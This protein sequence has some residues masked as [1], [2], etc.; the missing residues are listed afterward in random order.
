MSNKKKNFRLLVRTSDVAP[1]RIPQTPHSHPVFTYFENTRGLY[2]YLF[3]VLLIQFFVFN[4]Y[5]LLKKLYLFLDIGSDSY[6]L[7]YPSFVESARHIRTDGIPTWSFNSGMG[8]SIFPGGLSSPFM[9]P[10]YLLGPDKLAYG[11]IF[12]ELS[13]MM[14]AGCIF[15]LYLTLLKFSKYT[16]VIG[17]ILASCMGYMVL[18]SSGWYGHSTNVVYFFLLIYAF[19]LFYIKNNPVVFPIAVFFIASDAFKILIYSVFLFTYILFRLI[20]DNKLK[21]NESIVFLVKLAGLGA[22]GLGMSA[23][24][25]LES[26]LEKINS[27]RVTGKVKLT[28]S[29][30]STPVFGL[31]DRLEAATEILRSFSNDL[32][33]VGSKYTGFKNYL[34]APTFYSGLLPLLLAPQVFL[35]E[36]SRKKIVSGVFLVVWMVP[37]IFPFFRYGLYAFMGNYYKN[38]LSMFIPAII[39]IFGLNGLEAICRQRRHSLYVLLGTLGLLLTI[40]YI[41]YFAGPPYADKHF[42]D[43]DL[44]T[45]VSCFLI[46]Y[47]GILCFMRFEAARVYAKTLLMLIVCAEM[48][49]FSYITVNQRNA[50]TKGQMESRIG[51]N[52]YTVDAVDYIKS[53]DSGFYR[54]SKDY[55]SS[56]AEASS[57]NDAKIQDYF[58]TPSYS[59]FN[60][61]EYI[62]FLNATEIIPKGQESK[63]RWAIG[64]IQRPFLQAVASV[65]YNL[66]KNE[67]YAQR[68]I[69]FKMVYENVVSFGDVTVLKNNFFLPLGFTYDQIIL[70]KDYESLSKPHKDMAM[71]CAALMDKEFPPLKTITASDMALTLKNFKLSDFSQMVGQ[72][73]AQAMKMTS[74]TQKHITGEI[75]IDSPQILFFSI[76]VDGGWKAFVNSVPAPLVKVNI[77]FMGLLLKPGTYHVDLRYQVNYIMATIPVSILFVLIYLAVVFRKKLL[78]FFPLDSFSSIHGRDA[79]K[80]E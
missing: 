14:I 31:P 53:I 52:D 38:G 26:L 10:L 71:F 20:S 69:F 58:G 1:V 23:V 47:A 17:G 77:G 42:I 19:E 48:G 78:R 40:L 24:F 13:K 63:T 70:R 7:F 33:G 55:S 45:L 22:I 39:L 51:Y 27:P 62:D 11:I 61:N 68:D 41:P 79:L 5:I 2:I 54:I 65:K 4:D 35:I 16:S 25:S 3:L 36:N 32:L 46:I 64:L 44:R 72:K 8:E 74:F 75:S 80:N 57:I 67:D 28:G 43:K 29:L 56:P 73:R 66:L 50:L 76:P 49:W 60:R 30:M 12:V 37:L 59:S 15:Y 9:W 21:L 34:E 6:N 18:G